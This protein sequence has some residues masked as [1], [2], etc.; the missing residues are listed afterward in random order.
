MDADILKLWRSGKDTVLIAHEIGVE[1]NEIVREADIANRL[2][3]IRDASR[4]PQPNEA[5]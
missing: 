3:V 1:H 2:A 5:A 4:A